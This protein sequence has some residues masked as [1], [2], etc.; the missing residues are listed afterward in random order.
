MFYAPALPPSCLDCS[1]IATIPTHARTNSHPHEPTYIQT[2]PHTHTPRLPLAELDIIPHCAFAHPPRPAAA[3]GGERGESGVRGALAAAVFEAID[4]VIAG[5]AF[6]TLAPLQKAL[7][8][9]A[10]CVGGEITR[11]VCVWGGHALRFGMDRGLAGRVCDVMHRCF[12]KQ[13]QNRT[14]RINKVKEERFQTHE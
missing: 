2:H 6:F 9:R 14:N 10:V 3:R 11:A 12:I 5:P 8:K 1:D 7:I 4:W 13:E